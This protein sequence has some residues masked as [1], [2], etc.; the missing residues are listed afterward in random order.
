VIE[1][2]FVLLMNGRID[3]SRLVDRNQYSTSV[4]AQLF[5]PKGLVE[6]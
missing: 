5:V 3:L 6:V 2:F 4:A 1:E